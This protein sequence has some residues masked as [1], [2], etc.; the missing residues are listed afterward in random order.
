[1]SHPTPD[2]DVRVPV[3]HQLLRCLGCWWAL[4]CSAED[5]ARY[6]AAGCVVCGGPVRRE[7]LLPGPPAAPAPDPAR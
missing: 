5:V 1:M 7:S 2:L 4:E 3:S 6:A